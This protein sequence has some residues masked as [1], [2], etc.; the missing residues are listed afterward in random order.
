MWCYLSA[1]TR[2]MS[3]L[4]FALRFSSRQNI[5]LLFFSPVSVPVPCCAWCY[6]KHD[7]VKNKEVMFSEIVTPQAN[8]KPAWELLPVLLIH[9]ECAWRRF[10]KHIPHRSLSQSCFFPLSLCHSLS[11][12]SLFLLLILFHR[13]GVQL[14]SFFSLNSFP[15]LRLSLCVI[16][17]GFKERL[18]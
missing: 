12:S 11:I 7:C 18:T 8:L 10:L 16:V 1:T 17:L 14:L 5:Q 15:S 3:L 6:A 9:R 13:Q 2:F 4:L